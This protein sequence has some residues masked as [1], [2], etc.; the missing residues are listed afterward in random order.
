M[1]T[2][3]WRTAAAVAITS[4]VLLACIVIDIVKAPVVLYFAAI[5]AF[6]QLVLWLRGRPCNML[7]PIPAVALIGVKLW[8]MFLGFRS[9][10]WM[11]F[12]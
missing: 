3:A 6:V 1:K 12:V 11:E 9:P 7:E 8:M 2:S 10:R 5:F 4:P